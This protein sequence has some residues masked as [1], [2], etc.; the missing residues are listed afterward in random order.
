MTTP[1]TPQTSDRPVIGPSSPALVHT[2]AQS[3][4]ARQ[5]INEWER[6]SISRP[7]LRKVNS[8]GLTAEPISHLDEMLVHAGFGRP[9]DDCAADHVLW[10]LICRAEHDELAARIV[11]HRVLPSVLSIAQR[12]GRIMRGGM[13]AAL[14]E[15]I[16]TAWMVIRTFPHERRQAKIAANLARDIEY[17][18]FVRETRLRS[19]DIDHSGHHYIPMLPNTATYVDPAEEIHE[20]ISDAATAGLSR[21]HVSLLRDIANGVSTVDAAKARNLSPRT[22]R[23][24]KNHAINAF[25]RVHKKSLNV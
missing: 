20:L 21:R 11:L 4:P 13:S 12:R 18:A 10:K 14:D 19:V 7:A 24:H 6:L 3:G 16:P 2:T 9:T 15:V 17:H 5:L 23:N 25:L 22:M 1:H 8:W